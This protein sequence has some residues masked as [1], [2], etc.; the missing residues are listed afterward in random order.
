MANVSKLLYSSTASAPH[1]LANIKAEDDDLRLARQLIR[2]HLR[3]AFDKGGVAAFGLAIRPR[4]FTQGSHAYKTLNDPAWTPP[5]QKDLDDGCYLPMSFVKGLGPVGRS[6]PS[7]AADAFFKFVDKALIELAAQHEG[8]RFVK[9]PTCARLIISKSAHVDVPLYAIPDAEFAQLQE[10]VNKHVLASKDA[11]RPDRWDALPEDAVLLA[12]REEDWIVSDPRKIHTWFLE[13]V[14]TYGEALRRVCRYL[15]AWR[16]HHQP[17]LDGVSSILLMACAFMA[18][19]EKTRQLLP[20]REDEILL[21]VVKKL[22]TLLNQDIPNPA[23]SSENLN[24]MAAEQRKLAVSKAEEFR[25]RLSRAVTTSTVAKDAVANMMSIF[26]ERLPDRPDLVT[27]AETATVTVLSQ[28]RKEVAAPVV[29]RST[30][31]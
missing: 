13:A 23:V 21:L 28:P 4:F 11:K 18:F 24:R 19:E 20:N 8:W 6:K 31:G 3:A 30:S 26:G 22:P 1:F 29:G 27:I 10:R 7:V 16:D 25:T 15:K 5:Q 17:H 12:H 14:D 9:K 2:D